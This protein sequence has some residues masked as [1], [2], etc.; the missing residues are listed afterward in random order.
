MNSLIAQEVVTRQIQT[1]EDQ[2]DS[3]ENRQTHRTEIK[4]LRKKTITKDLIDSKENRQTHH[5]E[6]KILRK[7]AITEE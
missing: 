7:Q 4:I 1:T 5:T 6:I 2:I 3:R